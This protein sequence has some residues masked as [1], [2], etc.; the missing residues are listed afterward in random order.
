MAIDIELEPDK[1]R[2]LRNSLEDINLDYEEFLTDEFIQEHFPF[3]GR[4]DFLRS[5]GWLTERDQI[6][7]R[8]TVGDADEFIS[9]HSTFDT[10]HQL[11]DA[12]LQSYYDSPHR[13]RRDK[14]RT[15][16][17]LAT[18]IEAGQQ[19]LSGT[20]KDISPNGFRVELNSSL[21]NVR[22]LKAHLDAPNRA[23]ELTLR[24]VVRWFSDDRTMIGVEILSKQKP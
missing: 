23:G 7:Y 24:G 19:Q 20:I 12:A 13:N 11:L 1:V 18:R 16:C 8:V 4:R 9:E 2:S 10:W 22:T 5:A 6:D 15:E 21:P 17:S 3:E 14:E